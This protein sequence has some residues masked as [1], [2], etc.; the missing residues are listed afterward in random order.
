MFPLVVL[1][2]WDCY[3]SHVAMTF[4]SH[5]AIITYLSGLGFQDF[6]RQMPLSPSLPR[7]FHNKPNVLFGTQAQSKKLEQTQCS[8]W[9][10]TQS[11]KP[12]EPLGTQAQSKKPVEGE[13]PTSAFS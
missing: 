4:F 7:L 3:S 8:V 10:P 12:E 2:T 6:D 11:K 9:Y 13:A 1:L 5:A